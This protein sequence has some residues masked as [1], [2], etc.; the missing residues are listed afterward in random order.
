VKH[1]N[2]FLRSLGNQFTSGL[3]FVVLLFSAI[4]PAI[5][6]AETTPGGGGATAASNTVNIVPNQPD[7][8]C[9]G[10]VYDTSN[11]VNAQ[12]FTN[13]TTVSSLN[14]KGNTTT[15]LFQQLAGGNPGGNSGSVSLANTSIASL[16]IQA[17]TVFGQIAGGKEPVVSISL[18]AQSSNYSGACK[19]TLGFWRSQDGTDAT[20]YGLYFTPFSDVE[21]NEIAS[22]LQFV[23]GYV[24]DSTQ[25]IAFSI[26]GGQSYNLKLGG[27]ATLFKTYFGTTSGGS[28]TTGTAFS[29]CLSSHKKSLSTCT[30]HTQALFDNLSSISY[31]GDEYVATTWEDT[32]GTH[33][34]Y[35][36]VSSTTDQQL[37]ALHPYF[38]ITPH[39]ASS[40]KFDNLTLPSDT[41]ADYTALQQSLNNKTDLSIG[42]NSDLGNVNV[43]T[44]TL[45][46]NI[47]ANYYPAND[48]IHP[49]FADGSGGQYENPYIGSYTKTS[50][51]T[52]TYTGGGVAGC[53]QSDQKP[54]FNLSAAPVAVT[55]G[56][57]SVTGTW[58]FVDATSCDAVDIPVTV[59][60]EPT[61]ATDTTY[62][63]PVVTTPISKSTGDNG[64][65]TQLS[66]ESS[67]FSLSWIV[68]PVIT[69]LAGAVDGVY[70]NFIQPLLVTKSIDITGTGKCTIG[71]GASGS[72]AVADSTGNYSGCDF[73]VWSDF[74]VLGDIFLLIA[75]LV[76]VF[77]QSIGGG[78]IDAY[79]AKKILPRLL[80]SAVLINLS[81]YLVAAAVDITN[82]LGAGIQNLIEA[83]IANAGAFHLSLGGD[84]AGTLGF[85]GIFGGAVA[86]G[87]I[88]AAVATGGAVLG[89]VLSF[90]GLFVLLPAVLLFIAI[91]AT[92]LLRR[93]VIIFLVL[94]S[95]VALA[96]YCLP[97]TEKYFRR[98]LDLFIRTLLV[99]PLIAGI[100]AMGEVMSVFIQQGSTTSGPTAYIGQ[101]LSVVS[102]I[103]PLFLIPFSFRLAGGIIGKVHDTLLG[104]N[105]RG[106][107]AVKGNPNDPNSLRNFTRRNM[108]DA[109]VR[110]RGKGVS[111]LSDYNKGRTAMGKRGVRSFAAGRL[112]R[113]LNYGDLELKE[114]ILNKEQGDQREI[115]TG[116]GPD[117]SVR[118]LFTKRNS[119][120]Q[121][122][123]IT[124]GE[125][126]SDVQEA[127]A[128]RL[129][130]SSLSSIHSALDYEAGKPGNKAEYLAMREMLPEVMMGKLNLDE[131]QMNNTVK[132]V[133]FK[134]QTKRLDM[135][136][137]SYEKNAD[138]KYVAKVNYA[139]MNQDFAEN[140]GQYAASNMKDVN[141][142]AMSEGYDRA[143]QALSDD[144][145]LKTYFKGDRNL[146]QR[147][148]DDAHSS[149]D[150][151]ESGRRMGGTGQRVGG[152]EGDPAVSTGGF[153]APGHVQDAMNGYIDKVTASGAFKAAR[154]RPQ[155]PQRPQPP[156][157]AGSG[158]P[159]II[160]PPRGYTGG[161]G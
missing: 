50:D 63:T 126:F 123:S 15:D 125:I 26:P 23:E 121:W 76:I 132:G 32:S 72:V 47:V 6:S 61:D 3:F 91:L 46:L 143:T 21:N 65:D 117:S 56:G 10:A 111:T 74:R 81:I 131:H 129:S 25:S 87:T 105:K 8:Q 60:I 120:G 22:S 106:I 70:S 112:G 19:G 27:D 36:L 38:E 75:L 83:P 30:E 130:G 98:W 11:P 41:V 118:A 157:A 57:G 12:D 84:T 85:T 2:F 89:P 133:G 102:F 48:T 122:E 67:G 134:A 127:A 141:F 29:D 77:G 39:G 147:T 5:A 35:N 110:M 14:G 116:H 7:A 54:A 97:N 34:R 149:V 86:G 150:A 40:G 24:D 104:M 37:L 109:G 103:I 52:Y 107:E 59:Q 1:Q 148:L 95:P 161:Q 128:R 100:F 78:L 4:T 93:G 16:P 44:A 144:N 69:G 31:M 20:V 28:T 101:L 80:I 45:G 119:K 58:H 66:C 43:D 82:V 140:F 108:R 113:A 17:K 99:Y 135:K 18:D 124:N 139:G 92:V 142:D 42:Y 13:E 151:L 33:F 73:K 68:C 55:R 90:L 114:S 64:A 138:G 160:V 53:T 154:P 145:A 71:S 146:A 51:T 9:D 115:K 137:T 136:Y 62:T 159:T 158:G 152:E 94:S 155:G 96:L 49:V 79:A 153:G 156:Q 88:W